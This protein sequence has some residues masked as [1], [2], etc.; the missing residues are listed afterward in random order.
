MEIEMAMNNKIESIQALRGI[1]A[2]MVVLGHMN[3]YLNGAYAQDNL[4]DLL[5]FNGAIGVDIFFI[6]SGFIIVLATEKKE[7]S[8]T[9]KFIIKRVFRIYPTYLICL[10]VFCFFASGLFFISE[11]DIPLWLNA[12]NIISSLAFMPLNP[13]EAAPFYG[14][15][16]VI[17]AWTL[18][19]EM[20]FYLI[21][22]ISMMISHKYRGVIS[23]LFIIIV[24]IIIQYK[25][26][27]VFLFNAY[28]VSGIESSRFMTIAEN[29]ISFD[30]ILGII[31][32]YIFKAL[33]KINLG[34]LAKYLSVIGVSFG[35]LCWASGFMFGHG[36]TKFGIIAFLIFISV[37]I[38][39]MV[40]KFNVNKK[41][42][43]FGDISY[44][45][46]ISHV[47]VMFGFSEYKKSIPF[48][49]HDNGFM[50][51]FVVLFTSLLFSFFL[52]KFIEKPSIN[53]AGSIC[54]KL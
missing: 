10:F 27:G 14:Y 22:A 6:I 31:S 19:Y 26:N 16:L 30:F 18:S 50:L 7:T 49:P 24:S 34:V 44:S 3:V 47:V 20:Y 1:A 17:T 53:L 48:I 43:F 45:V 13:S 41:L 35:I 40:F 21:F 9:M 4:G 33:K 29:P 23:S 46:Y 42:I 37:V 8:Q 32:F 11:R 12:S 54:K 2:M 28:S 51:F 5:F 38:G 52:Y 36:I 25:N 15:S 39:E